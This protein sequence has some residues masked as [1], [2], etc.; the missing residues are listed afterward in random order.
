M[1]QPRI[2][3]FT[4]SMNPILYRASM[5][6]IDLPY[7][8]V[9]VTGASSLGYLLQVIEDQTADVAINIDEDAFVTD[10]TALRSLIAHVV[11]GD[12]VN[13]GMPDGGVVPIRHHHPR[14][15]NPYFTIMN[16]ARIRE[17]LVPDVY[18]GHPLNDESCLADHP[19]RLL[20]TPWNLD[21]Y[22]PYNERLAWIAANFST[23][24]LDAE[25]HR[26]KIST[27]LHNQDD[28]P[29]LIHT[30]YS[31]TYGRELAGTRR[32]NAIMTESVHENPS[33]RPPS[34]KDKAL[35]TGQLL[36]TAAYQV[37]RRVKST[38]KKAS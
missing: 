35:V 25:P 27:V 16:T 28:V 1:G 13:C 36:T 9:R 31:R 7:P 10:P 11:E 22:E 12:Y 32:I 15:T 21:G 20:R 4:R 37:Q 19:R 14:V 38:T 23:L 26:D 2:K 8:K 34:N 3:L 29:F 18:S 30:W 24:Y 17:L 33:G 5:S 6:F